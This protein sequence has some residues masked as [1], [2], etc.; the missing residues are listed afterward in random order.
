MW[1]GDTFG[2]PDGA[3]VVARTEAGP[4][5]FTLGPHLLVQFHPEAT[6]E[7]VSAWLAYDDA[8]FRVAGI[9][10]EATLAELRANQEEARARAETML[11]RF[12]GGVS[13]RS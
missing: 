10:P 5:A 1:H 3:T 7:I 13:T 12:L 6:A 4:Q 11:D 8:D 9:D 2:P